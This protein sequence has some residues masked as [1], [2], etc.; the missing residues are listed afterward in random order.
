M[1]EKMLS[2]VLTGCLDNNC[3]QGCLFFGLKDVLGGVSMSIQ[4]S[5]KAVAFDRSFC[6]N[7]FI[8]RDE[9]M[10]DTRSNRSAYSSIE[11]G[12]PTLTLVPFTSIA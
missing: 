4:K 5:L 10:T 6:V 7:I 9:S 1:L 2:G 3:N 8:F 12:M 11:A